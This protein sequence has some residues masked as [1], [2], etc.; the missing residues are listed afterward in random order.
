ML[1]TQARSWVLPWYRLKVQAPVEQ[2][3]CH[4]GLW[5]SCQQQVLQAGSHPCCGRDQVQALLL[6]P[7]SSD[8]YHLL[9]RPCLHQ[10]RQPDCCCVLRLGMPGLKQGA[11]GYQIP[12]QQPALRRRGVWSEM[13]VAGCGI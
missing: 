11:Q 8:V 3:D 13:H 6:L 2:Y 7:A 1:R 4:E 12:L 10:Q 5:L 9:S